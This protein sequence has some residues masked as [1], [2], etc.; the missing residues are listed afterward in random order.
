MVNILTTHGRS[1]SYP[2]TGLQSAFARL[3]RSK[4]VV[5]LGCWLNHGMHNLYL[6]SYFFWSLLLSD[7]LVIVPTKER[8]RIIAGIS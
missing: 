6:S 7:K 3:R 2:T 5:P 8:N 1:P 4:K